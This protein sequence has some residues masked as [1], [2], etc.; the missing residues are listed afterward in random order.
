MNKNKE[1]TSI[2]PESVLASVKEML[3]VS[4]A[5]FDRR[6]Q[7]LRDTQAEVAE[8][9]K[10]TERILRENTEY[11][12][13]TERILKENAEYRK[14]TERILK[15]NAEYRKDTE[16][17]LK[18]NAEQQKDTDRLLKE[19][20]EQQKDT[21][22][23]I[24]ELGEQV[25]GWN[26][27]HGLFA[28][29][30]FFNSFNRGKKNFFGEKYDNIKKNLTGLVTD[31]EFDV[32]LLNG[33]SVAIIETKFKARSKD[34]NSAIKKV[35]AFKLNYP[36]Y[37]NHQFYIGMASMVFE[38]LAE[39]KCIEKGIAIIKQVGD[40]VVINDKHLKTF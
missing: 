30:Y 37:Q 35:N 2:T 38:K 14:D 16:R 15:E 13:E 22:R 10:E 18:E 8:Y 34:V 33:H 9:Q 1:H 19:N 32:V 39:T 21:D 25:G 24:K 3:A 6:M 27:S 28:E 4:G 29:E 36:N 5:E 23:L 7:E 40:T 26:N 11:R 31:D 17:I 12:K 20:A